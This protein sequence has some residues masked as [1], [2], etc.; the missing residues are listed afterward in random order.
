MRPSSSIGLKI[1]VHL[2]SDQL[3]YGNLV[4]VVL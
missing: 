1:L 2:N 4:G 3:N